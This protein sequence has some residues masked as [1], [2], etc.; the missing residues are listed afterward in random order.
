MNDVVNLHLPAW[1]HDSQLTG[2]MRYGAMGF[3]QMPPELKS[4][5]LC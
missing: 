2:T 5:T 1:R 3:G 4:Y